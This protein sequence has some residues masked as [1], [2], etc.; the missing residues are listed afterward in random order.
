MCC[1]LKK[2]EKVLNRWWW[3]GWSI[4]IRYKFEY[5]VYTTDSG[6]RP[7]TCDEWMGVGLCWV[8]IRWNEWV[9]WTFYK[10]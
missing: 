6:S 7:W 1:K 2:E 8:V 10:I 9:K 3:Y 4:T 5:I